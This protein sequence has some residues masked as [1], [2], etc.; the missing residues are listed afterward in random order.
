MRQS[1]TVD[2]KTVMR[3]DAIYMYARWGV[4][5]IWEKLGILPHRMDEEASEF[6][7]GYRAAA[8]RAGNIV[9]PNLREDY[10]TNMFTQSIDNE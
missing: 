7:R 3:D 8:M 10:R 1:K 2:T 4:R 5:G 6:V 9:G